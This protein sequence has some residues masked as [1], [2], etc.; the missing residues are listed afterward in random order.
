MNTTLITK[1]ILKK[2]R[3]KRPVFMP[4]A[5]NLFNEN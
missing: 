2:M 3:P 5:L 1:E 4:L